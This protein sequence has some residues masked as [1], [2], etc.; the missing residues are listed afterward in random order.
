[1]NI[2]KKI[3]LKN[4]YNKIKNEFNLVNNNI[5]VLENN[6][7]FVD[8]NIQEYYSY[9]LMILKEKSNS[10]IIKAKDIFNAIS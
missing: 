9:E 2:I 6:Y 1:M 8:R 5:I 7:N 10:L 3:L 4:S